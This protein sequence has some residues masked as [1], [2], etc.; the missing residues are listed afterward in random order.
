ML[1]R[2]TDLRQAAIGFSGWNTDPDGA[3]YRSM[4]GRAQFYVPADT[5]SLRFGYRVA[6]G[7]KRPI[8]DVELRV[9]GTVAD[10]VRASRHAWREVGLVFHAGARPGFRR[11]ELRTVTAPDVELLVGAAQLSDCRSRAAPSR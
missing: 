6:P 9:D 8:A 11:I 10:R 3:R 7:D 2:E 1:D 5:C 4:S